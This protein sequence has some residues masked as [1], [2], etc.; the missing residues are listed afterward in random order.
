[1][2]SRQRFHE[3]LSYGAPD[4]VPY[5]E[6][7]LR[8][9]VL[10]EWRRQG[11]PVGVDPCELFETDRRE[12]I[13]VS[14]DPI[15]GLKDWQPDAEG[16]KQL[17][18]CL[19]PHDPR[20]WPD[21]W[22]ECVKRWRDREHVLELPLHRGFF[23]T[24]QVHAWDQFLNALFP[25]MDTPDLVREVFDLAAR[26]SLGILDRV[27]SEVEVD[28]VSFSEPIGGNDRPLLSPAQYE[29][30]L[31]PG[32]RAIIDA[33]RQRGVQWFCWTTYANGRPLLPGVVAAGFNVLWACEAET[34]AM[35]YRSIR[36]EFGRDLRLIGG[37]DLDV[38]LRSKEEVEQEIRT[39]APPLLADGGYL[40]LADGRVR[41]NVP[42]EHYRFY[43]ELL[44]EVATTARAC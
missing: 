17:A 32:Y 15:P 8:D 23:L 30:F 38:L 29:A 43:R 25:L 31:L 18:R 42:F 6:E 12:R 7:G 28:Y 26:C 5:F 4:R 20:R 14:L 9:E 11:L 44:A 24:M 41:K 35:D 1:M 33:A 34:R 16:V 19:D 13:P 37:I 2:T 36:A 10:E 27:L 39:K 22:D 3:T 40:P 21:D